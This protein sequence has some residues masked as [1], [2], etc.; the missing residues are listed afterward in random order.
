MNKQT[1]L[2]WDYDDKGVTFAVYDDQGQRTPYQ[3]W[4]LHPIN[5]GE[6]TG[7]VSPIL[8]RVSDGEAEVIDD[9][10][11]FISHTVLAS[12][13][14]FE[15]KQVGLP[16]IAP[17]RLKIKGRGILTSP[18]FLFQYQLVTK[19]CRPVMGYKRKGA[20]LEVGS[21]QYS[22]LDPLYHLLEG[23][24]AFN[25]TPPEDMD[26]RFLRWSELKDYL[27]PKAIVDKHLASLEIVRADSF[28]LDIKD[29]SGFDPVL[30]HSIAKGEDY[31]EQNESPKKESLLPDKH[32]NN[33][34]NRFVSFREARNRYALGHNWY[35]V[36]PESLRQALSVVHQ[37]RKAS[38]SQRQA[39][40]ANPQAVLKEQMPDTVPEDV[41]D[42][43]FEETEE[44]LSSRV[45]CLGVWQP[46]ICAY[47]VPKRH[48]WFPDE[49]TEINVILD[50]GIYKITVKDILEVIAQVEKA[51]ENDK[52]KVIFKGETFPATEETVNV[53]K[54]LIQP[55][56][57]ADEQTDESSEA[58][59]SSEKIVPIIIDNIEEAIFKA[60][61]RRVISVSD[62][63]PT[64]LK[65]TLFK[66]QLDGVRWL[67]NHWA[68]GS[69]GSLLADDMGLG[70]T[71]QA[72]AFLAWVQQ[73][74]DSGVYPKRPFLIVAPAGL[75]KNWEDEAEI[76]LE[77][78]GLGEIFRA[79]GSDMRRLK[80]MGHFTRSSHLRDSD[81]VVTTYE[82][83]RDKIR[84]FLG[85]DWSVVIFDEIQKIKNPSSR[86]TEMAKS[87][88][89]DF[90]L[91]LTGT[92]VENRLADLWCI[93]DTCQAGY[94]GSLKKF[95]NEYEL[96]AEKDPNV[97]QE[98]KKL[99]IYD[100]KTIPAIMLRRMKE[101]HLTGLPRKK[102]NMID[103]T[104]DPIQAAAYSEAIRR[105]RENREE[106]GAMLKALHELRK[107][108]LLP[109][110]VD[111]AGL[112]DEMVSFSA[113]L[114]ALFEILDEVSEK[115]EKTLI[116]LEFLALQKALVP[117]IQQRY[118]LPT[119]PLRIHGGVSGRIR[120]KHVDTFQKSLPG[121]FNVMILS[122]R[123]GGVGLT[124]TAANHVVHL[125]RWWNP[126]VEDQCTD[127]LYRIGQKKPV[128]IYFPLAIHPEIKER[129]FDLNLHR[130]L[131]KKRALSR[132][133]LAPPTA[134]KNEIQELYQ[135][136]I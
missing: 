39:F 60:T 45:S 38:I 27:P 6:K 3:K 18:Q 56:P 79:Y 115:G 29:D 134:S 65:S 96:N 12:F 19:E 57:T 135:A 62:E 132:S 1:S 112:T 9:S 108:S 125:S 95:H 40:I 75:L 74:M 98:L 4:A 131:E 107:V 71:V 26:D 61:P 72:L 66:H 92:P 133:V 102:E 105:G 24:K 127:R 78:Y 58:D 33:F 97:G 81:W 7:S 88:K 91:A 121:E 136:S 70:K 69:T 59:R 114:R 100:Q 20:I 17:Y 23:M 30:L 68:S 47:V 101:D 113:R 123:A 103:K 31:Q 55:R 2:K 90:F 80:H 87:V 120:K 117:Y 128:H 49:E 46:K 85:I 124:L 94:L 36:V 119:P 35:V 130:L 109:T 82:T 116:F 16:L 11:V 51:I 53:L 42:C 99:L 43:L 52:D 22:I 25:A 86:M 122:P 76:H 21:K 77:G 48:D 110:P 84:Y 14:G 129:S 8:A 41:I 10:A 106:R 63:L 50:N 73:Q 28:T 83:L 118:N 104:M 13:E 54:R 111:D 5:V 34:A 44:F 67:Q 37:M 126:A 64:I 93:V 15:V 89:A 32:Q